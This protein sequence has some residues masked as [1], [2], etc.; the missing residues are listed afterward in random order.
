MPL[1]QVQQGE[2]IRKG[3]FCDLFLLAFLLLHL[4]HQPCGYQSPSPTELSEVG[5][6]ACD[7]PPVAEEASRVWRSGQFFVS[8][9]EQEKL[10]TTRG[11][12]TFRGP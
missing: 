6:K 4:R 5:G 2:P 7:A 10:G 11:S 9:S 3:R 12:V 8:V 1:V